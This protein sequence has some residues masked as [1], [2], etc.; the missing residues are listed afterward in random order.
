[1][2][3]TEKRTISTNERNEQIFKLYEDIVVKNLQRY[4]DGEG[5]DTEAMQA[6]SDS[7]RILHHIAQMRG[8]VP[9]GSLG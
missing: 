2:N 1:M 5:I 6:L 9:R 7:M 8:F 4:K 3:E